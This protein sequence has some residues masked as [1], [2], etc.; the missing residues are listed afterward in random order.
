MTFKSKFPA[1]RQICANL[2]SSAASAATLAFCMSL[3]LCGCILLF[4]L[5]CDRPK[6]ASDRLDPKT[7]LTKV[8]VGYIGITCE[9]P[10]FSAV[11]KGF[12]TEEG[13][14]PE[15]VKCEWSKYKDVLALGGYDITHH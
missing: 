6:S 15:L 14:E 11:E 1:P 4:S 13:I 10:I 9:A 7:G 2:R 8:K 3:F 5:S 12:F